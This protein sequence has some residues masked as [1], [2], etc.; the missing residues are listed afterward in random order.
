[1]EGREI[2]F[3]PKNLYEITSQEM[4]FNKNDDE[5]YYY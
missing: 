5:Y 3:P 1:M 4:V 2:D